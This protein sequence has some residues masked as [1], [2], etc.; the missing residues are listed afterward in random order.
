MSLNLGTQQLLSNGT[1]YFSYSGVRQGDITLPATISLMTIDNAGLRDSLVCFQ[2]YYGQPIGLGATDTL[3]IIVSID[4][5]EVYKSQGTDYRP[6]V[7]NDEVKLFVPRQSKIQILSLNTVANNL[8]E[9][10][11]NLIGYYL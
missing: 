3:G 2:A 11:C 7:Y 10:G 4:D 5:I 6:Q 1:K 8:Q 9:R